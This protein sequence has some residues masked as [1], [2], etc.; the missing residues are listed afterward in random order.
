MEARKEEIP[1]ASASSGRRARGK[2]PGGSVRVPRRGGVP[3]SSGRGRD[4]GAPPPPD[5]PEPVDPVRGTSTIAR[6]RGV[7]NRVVLALLALAIPPGFGGC[8]DALA[9]DV[10]NRRPLTPAPVYTD[11]WSE[12][13]SCSGQSGDMARVEWSI[14]LA[15]K[16]N[17]RQVVGHWRPPHDILLREGK[18]LDPLVVKHE[19]LHDLLQ[20]DAAHSSPAWEDCGVRAE[21]RE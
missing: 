15:I 7:R 14:A 20:G 11:W 19:M 3:A 4:G 10:S 9:V 16:V 2:V 21:D 5:P 12:I 6:R 13:E 18:E 17:G 1:A 8:D